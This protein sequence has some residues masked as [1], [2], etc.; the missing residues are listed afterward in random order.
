[1]KDAFEALGFERRPALDLDELQERY[2][3]QA[4]LLHPDSEGGNA[5]AFAEIGGARALLKDPAERLYHLIQLQGGSITPS[6][7][8]EV[9]E[10]MDLA[11]LLLEAE[12]RISRLSASRTSLARAVLIGPGRECLGRLEQA[13]ERIRLLLERLDAELQAAD[14]SWPEVPLSELARIATALR[15]VQKRKQQISES[16]FQLR[17]ALV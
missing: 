5:Q 10:M 3:R 16:C 17:N 11:S 14:R 13:E 4:A 2:L 12:Q 8:G 9:Q 15:F 6:L 7:V 1:M